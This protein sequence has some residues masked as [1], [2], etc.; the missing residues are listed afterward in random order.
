MSGEYAMLKT[1]A[2]NGWLDDKQCMME[3]LVAFKRAGAHG[4]LNDSALD[5]AA[6][7]KAGSR[8]APVNPSAPGLDNP[9]IE[10][11]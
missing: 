6:L 8:S 3:V 9:H 2:Q 7:L 1:A 4:V 11:V 10:S 5:A